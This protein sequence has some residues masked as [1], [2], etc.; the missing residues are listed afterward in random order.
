MHRD[1]YHPR[2]YMLARRGGRRRLRDPHRLNGSMRLLWERRPWVETVRNHP[3]V[4]L[5][6][7]RHWRRAAKTLTRRVIVHSKT[8]ASCGLG[9]SDINNR[10][11]IWPIWAQSED[12][13]TAPPR[14]DEKSCR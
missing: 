3:H 6:A 11:W 4:R 9:A 2:V 14:C 12:G 7:P 5:V 10:E 1:V 13:Q 8:G